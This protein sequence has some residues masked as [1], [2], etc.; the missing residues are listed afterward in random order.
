MRNSMRHT[1][2]SAFCM[3]GLAAAMPMAANA[4]NSSGGVVNSDALSLE[5][6]A[7]PNAMRGVELSPDGKFV[8]LI[9][10]RTKT[11][12]PII[13]VFE[14]NDLSKKPYRVGADSLEITG[15]NWI[16]S[17]DMTISFRRQVRSSARGFNRSAFATKLARFSMNDKKFEELTNDSLTISLV[18]RLVHDDKHV[19]MRH[20]EFDR[21]SSFRAPIFNKVNLKTG[22]KTLVL[23]GNEDLGNYRFDAEGNPWFAAG[24]EG[25]E[26]IFYYRKPGSKDWK[27]FRRVNRD[28]FEEF[29]PQTRLADD[30]SRLYVVAH[31]G[32][33]KK[34]LWIYNMDTKSFEDLVYRRKDVDVAGVGTHTNSWTYPNA[35]TRV[36]YA[37]EKFHRKYF[38]E[39]EKAIIAQ[40]ENAIPNAYQVAITSRSKDGNVMVIRNVGPKDPGS[41]Y[42]YNDGAFGKLGSV[43]GLLTAKDLSEVEY[44]TYKA[45]DGKTIPGYLTKPKGAGPHPLVVMPHGGPFSEET[46]IFDEWSQ[47]L[48]NNGYMVL[49]PQFRGSKNYGL[50][51]YKSAFINGGEGGGKM[52]DDKDDGAKHLIAQGLVDPDR[53]AMF[54]WSY[55]GYAS[56]IAASRPN[57]IYQCVIAGAAVADN[58]QQVN[59][60]RNQLRGAQQVEQ[61][62]FWDGSMSPIEEVDKVN[63]PIMLIHG[64]IDQRVGIKHSNKYVSALKKANKE[65]KYLELKDADH[66]LSTLRFDHKM[67][68]YPALVDFLQKDCGPNG[69]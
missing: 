21:R 62:Q 51:F 27:E 44:I 12:D 42:L 32:N 68:M 58:L 55:G 33:D 31:N 43:N 5:Y 69:L 52:Q 50:D 63:V 37:K 16:S 48:A 3:M 53:V 8:A 10:N 19:L 56:L 15:F 65:H 39:D 25:K 47:M 35:V 30:P 36:S 38:D 67:E 28:D 46:V 4:T 14:T 1:V 6:W 57:N 13:E 20:S 2:L 64:S 49:Q 41:F 26:T 45:R 7:L 18:S 61:L 24:R 29:I 11:G 60:Y 66:F 34:G 54:G 40:F 59:L 17:T 22:A 23:K 9:R